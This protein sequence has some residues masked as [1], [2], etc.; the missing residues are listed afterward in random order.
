MAKQEAGAI[1]LDPKKTS[2]YK[3][4]QFWINTADADVIR[5]L[6][7]FTLQRAKEEIDVLEQKHQKNPEARE[8]HRALAAEMTLLIH[9]E[10]AL[11]KAQIVPARF[12][13][14][15]GRRHSQPGPLIFLTKSIGESSDKRN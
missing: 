15:G 7:F 5:Y 11:H 8:A 6:K 10:G 14:G 4:Y 9:G 2:V 3:F 1:W 13:F 12:L